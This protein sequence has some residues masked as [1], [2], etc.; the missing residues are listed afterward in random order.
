MEARSEIVAE[1]EAEVEAIGRCRK[2]LMAPT[3]NFRRKSQ[4][5]GMARRVT[6][7]R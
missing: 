7:C 6:P 5:G 4:R 1:A 2:S 3:Y